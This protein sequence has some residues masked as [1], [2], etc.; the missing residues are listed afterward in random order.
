VGISTTPPLHRVFVG[1]NGAQ[2]G[3]KGLVPAPA[4]ADNLKFLRGDGSWSATD[5][6]PAVIVAPSS[7]SRNVIQPTNSA[8][9]PLTVK[10]A[11]GQT[12]NLQQWQ[13]SAGTA[14]ASISAG[15]FATLA[16]ADLG[17]STSSPNLSAML[18]N[19]FI[20]RMSDLTHMIALDFQDD[21]AYAHRRPGTI[22]LST[23]ASLGDGTEMFVDSSSTTDWNTGTSPFPLQ[24]EVDVSSNP[25]LANRIGVYSVGLTFRTTGNA[26]PTH[27]KIEFWDNSA[28]AYANPAYDAD[29]SITGGPTF[30]LSPSM[31]AP[32]SGSTFHVYKLRITLSGTNPIPAGATFRI[33]RLILYHAAAWDT[34]HLSIGG[35]TVYGATTIYPRGSATNTVSSALLLD[36]E[37]TGTPAA[38]FGTALLI[39]G[40]SDTARNRSM[41]RLYAQWATATDASRKASARWTVFDTAE[42]EVIRIEASG[43]AGMLGFFGV[44]AAARQA[45][46]ALTNAVTA[47]GSNDVIADITDLTTYSNA[48]TTIRNDIYQLARKV[49]EMSDALR[50]YG[51]LS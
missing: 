16:G 47:G 24:I 23:P 15:G 49:K 1:A 5:Y 50:L 3:A 19:F 43:S 35:G 33:Q 39:R 34:F 46:A 26:N 36:N 12:A 4:A 14:V 10:A 30:W 18:T 28:G 11:A 13:D 20:P 48:A 2:A 25:V 7:S 40:M 8:V 51:L 27:I 6:S 44:S 42:R 37:S 31:L 21:F 29:V 38:G 32:S 17:F 22:T 41:S 9:I 45:S